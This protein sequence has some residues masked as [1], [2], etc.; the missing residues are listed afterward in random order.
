MRLSMNW[1]KDYGLAVEPEALAQRLT[2]AGLEVDDMLPAA[3]AFSNIVIGEVK[4]LAAH[5]DADKL[6]VAMV[7]VGSGELLQIVCGAPNVAAGLKVPTALVGAQLPGEVKIK[8]SKL[9]GV[10]SHGMLCSAREL[11][12]SDDH[13]GLMLLPDD[14][15]V[16]V[17]I[18]QWLGLDDT[19]LDIDL[20]PNRAD[21]FSM[22]GLAREAGVLFNSDVDLA[23]PEVDV[24]GTPATITVS[25]SAA[26]ACP[27]YLL[28]EIKGVDVSRPTPLW[29]AERLRRAGVRP[30]DA[31]V[32][33]TNYVMMALGTP[34]HAFDA[35]KVNGAIRLRFARQGES[36]TLLN[37]QRVT[38]DEDV[39]VIAD[40]QQP[41]ALAGVMGG[42][43]SAC[44]AQTRDIILEAAWFD[45]VCIA[46]KA[47]RF[48]L[49]SD[50]AQRFERGVDFTLQDAAISLATQ[51]ITAICG[52]TVHAVVA[53]EHPEHLPT[54]ETITLR[55]AAIA[56]RIGRS[57]DDDLVMHI[58]QR[59]G[60]VVTVQDD[61]WQVTAPSWRFDLAI[62]EDLIEEIVRV[63]GYDQVEAVL[64]V[65]D[66]RPREAQDSLRLH[67]AKL[68]QAGFNEAITYS[69][70]DRASHAAFFAD[71]AVIPL[72]NPISAQLAEMRLSL[73]PGLVNALAY[74]RNR[75]QLDVRLF[76]TGKVFLPQGTRAV[77]CVQEMRIAGVLCGRAYPEQW[78]Q[79]SRMV[80]FYDVKGVVEDLLDGRGVYRPTTQAYL[81]PGQGADIILNGEYIGCLGALHPNVQQALAIKG[82]PVWVFE[83]RSDVLATPDVAA[84]RHIA[85]YPAVRRDLALVL[86]KSVA[87]EDI[88]ALIR[89][90]VG[91]CLADTF[92]FD[93][94]EGERL[95]AE[96]KS[97]AVAIILQDVDKTLQDEEVERMIAALIE[98]LQQSFNAELR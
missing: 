56:Q 80:D 38:L 54:R 2:M 68:V 52:G 48:G 19:V 57:Y 73:L 21:A 34:M 78:A 88:A 6:R 47:R 35:T 24:D 43:D 11:G 8:K 98:K 63:D 46:G 65:V 87:A 95:G 36:M 31:V 97:L 82:S 92:F 59:L 91:K 53:D 51:L 44:T 14:A 62:E 72:H 32:D 39:L 66:Y 17:D 33:V 50:S 42:G 69:F 5:P 27:R 94:Y 7:D 37:E 28:R 9:R 86:D 67:S 75:Q 61:G 85:K 64:P 41:L 25:N 77:D 76:E 26:A 96:K 22:R 23:L 74:N 15:P 55:R 81:H 13:A 49:S 60:C 20:T 3:P 71:A 30:H 89:R 90:E 79:D 16:G 12:I 58:L 40:A 70:I 18:R 29:L 93:L 10:A 4:S 1:L 45:P 84:F 83:L